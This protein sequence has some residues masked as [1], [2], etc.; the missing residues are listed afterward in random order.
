MKKKLI[1]ILGSTGSIGQQT[2]E[3]VSH[4]K[5]DFEIVGLSCNQNLTILKKQIQKFL[6]KNV[7]I[8]NKS[9]IPELKKFINSNKYK[10][11]I[12][13][14]DTGLEE[15]A[16]YDQDI[17]IVAIFGTISLK[18]T[19]IAIKKGT[20]IG[21][22]NKEIL[23]AAGIQIMELAKKFKV[24]IR[25]IDSEHA[26]LE[27]CIENQ[28]LED[29]NSVTLTASGGPFWQLKSD[30]FSN[31]EL[32]DTLKHP[33]W[34]MG[35]KITID[36]ATMMNKGF[37]VIEAHHLFNIPFEKIDVLIHP[38]SYVHAIANFK[39][40]TNLA[41]FSET[42]MKIPIQ[43][44]LFSPKVKKAPLPP[45]QF[46]DYTKL[47]FYPVD[48]IKFPLLKIA[49][50]A[51]KNGGSYPIVLNTCNDFANHLFQ[52]G[53]IKYPDIHKII[54]NYLDSHQKTN[55]K[56]ID[57]IIELENETTKHLKHIYG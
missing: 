20:S 44:A 51:G 10:T 17:L 12:L 3:V 5:E 7:H 22:A 23:V 32:N 16:K 27:Q 14:P 33:T 49:Y 28:K 54:K 13:D 30:Q 24:K 15:I 36:S 6:P 19:E 56:T 11:K 55:P 8:A 34:K 4:F 50:Q 25:P 26:A 43:K 1:S 18:P 40:G 37:E 35:K 53:K 9:L 38:Q 47:E 29:I 46:K 21:L 42:D 45:F 52:I 2:L 39:N 48:H 57:D 31:I 41:Q